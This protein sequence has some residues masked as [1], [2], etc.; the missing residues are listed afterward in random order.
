VNR[1]K[2]QPGNF[3]EDAMRKR[4]LAAIVVAALGASALPAQAAWKNY[5]NRELGFSFRAPGE[6]KTGSGTYQTEL[7]GAHQTIVYSAMEDD[8]EYK[9]TVVRFP[10][11]AEAASILGE[12]EYDFQD[13]K[14]VLLDT[15]ARVENGK[16][17]VFGRKL[18]IDLPDHKGRTTAA[19]YFTKGKLVA[20]EATVL[21]ANGDFAS[22]DP[23][24]FVDSI[25]F[26][27]R[28]GEPGA[29]ELANPKPQ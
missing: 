13:G 23:A 18:V 2:K 1:D 26:M 4:V 17:A 9:L 3:R 15:F 10:Q 11:A 14:T 29:I 7:A 5:V 24:L 16:D 22:P 8:I 27:L 28:R 19:F 20:L 6:L 25:T 12:R 21:P